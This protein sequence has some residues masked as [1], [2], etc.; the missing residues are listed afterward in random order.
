MIQ[1]KVL[2][3]KGWTRLGDLYV[4]IFVI[5]PIST[6]SRMSFLF[7]LSIYRARCNNSIVGNGN[8]LL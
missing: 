4:C 8:D 5:R 6:V 1:Y 2:R 3:N 7:S